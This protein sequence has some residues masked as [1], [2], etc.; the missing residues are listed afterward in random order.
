MNE[1]KDKDRTFLDFKTAWAIQ[2]ELGHTLIHDPRCSSVAGWHPLS[3]PHFLCD[4]GA[5][6]KYWEEEGWDK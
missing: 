4:C 3:G 5:V 2:K 6:L 1:T